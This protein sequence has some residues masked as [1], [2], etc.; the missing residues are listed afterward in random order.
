MDLKDYLKP[1]KKVSMEDRLFLV[2]HNAAKKSHITVDQE[3][4]KADPVKAV[5]FLC[6]AKVYELHK[7]TGECKV[8]FENCLECGTCQVSCRYVTWKNPDGSFGMTLKYG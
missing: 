4:F 3:K 6:P 2:S 7:E 8:S 1:P 5:T